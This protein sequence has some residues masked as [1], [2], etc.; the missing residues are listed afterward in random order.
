LVLA[1]GVIAT[2]TSK[3]LPHVVTRMLVSL[4]YAVG[5]IFVVLPIRAVHGADHVGGFTCSLASR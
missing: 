1:H 5:F 4:A 3:E 2:L